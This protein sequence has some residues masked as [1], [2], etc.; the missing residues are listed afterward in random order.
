MRPRV[1][2]VMPARAHLTGQN[3]DPGSS[4]I[5]ASSPPLPQAPLESALIVSLLKELVLSL[6]DEN[7]LEEGL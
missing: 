2:S 4:T 5:S 3:P 6:Y 1:S 7:F